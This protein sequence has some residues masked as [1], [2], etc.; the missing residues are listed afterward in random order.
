MS[1]NESRITQ[2]LDFLNEV[3]KLKLVFRR[4][5]VVDRSR[6]ENSAEHSWHIALMAIVLAEHADA[7]SLDV[8]R[9]VK[10]LLIHDLVEIDAG[11][12]WAYDTQAQ[13]KQPD[14]EESAAARLFG[15]LPAEQGAEFL[16]LWREFEARSTPEA[17]F[18]AS[19]DA[20]QPL[21]NHL[22][23]GEPEDPSLIPT[24]TA[25]LARKQHIAAASAALW[26]QAQS[27]IETS[28][29]K[30]LYRNE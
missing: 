4:N 18:A 15:M 11:D 17:A 30:G 1:P 22:I 24:K 21:T 2:Q 28:T 27:T 10:M 19:I 6:F 25:V 7:G 23:S 14:N 12:T 29:E 3:E 20:L 13:K 9:I 5:R 16:D 26:A 8:L